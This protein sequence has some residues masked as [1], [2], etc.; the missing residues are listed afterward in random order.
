MSEFAFQLLSP[1]TDGS[2]ATPLILCAMQGCS[3]SGPVSSISRSKGSFWS[4]HL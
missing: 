3:P 2:V 4:G 1:W